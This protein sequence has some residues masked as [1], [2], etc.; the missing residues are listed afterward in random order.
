MGSLSFAHRLSLTERR[1]LD[2]CIR[3]NQFYGIERTLEDLKEQGITASRSAL[4]RYM[5]AARETTK[6]L[7][8]GEQPTVVVLMDRRTGAVR[9]LHTDHSIDEIEA[10]IATK[11]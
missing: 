1:I 6:M 9:H 5:K 2:E 4:A 7:P 3:R 10:M 11:N 8:S